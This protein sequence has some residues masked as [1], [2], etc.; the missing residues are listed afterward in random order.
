MRISRVKQK[1]QQG[2]PAAITAVQ[3]VD[4]AIFEMVS[5]MGFDGIWMDMEHHF[6]SLETAGQLVRAARVGVAD[7]IARPAKGE[8]MRMGRMLEAGAAGIMYPRCESAEEAAEVVKWAK[9][10]PLGERGFDGA[11]PDSPYYSLPMADYIRQANEQ[12]LIIIQLESPVAIQRAKEIAAVDGVDVLMLGPADFSVLS[13]IPGQW[14]HALIHDA[15]Q[16][17]AS[18][19]EATGKNWGCP[20]FS[21]EH[22]SKMLE[23]GARF[24]CAYGDFIMIKNGMEQLQ[25]E[26]A[27]LGFT[28]QNQLYP[29]AKDTSETS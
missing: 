14:D 18:A 22:I 25:R 23:M 2:Q 7:V 21:P 6:H 17:I 20:G 27:P 16:Q 28:F 29:P 26:L 8:F 10:A 12:T 19:A 3:F 13:G 15:L 24:I 9:F 1:L 5:L 11:N 4:P